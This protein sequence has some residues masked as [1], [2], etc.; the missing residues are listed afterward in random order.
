MKLDTRQLFGITV[1]SASFA[2]L[3][4]G[5]VSAQTPPPSA[6]QAAKPAPRMM[7]RPFSKPTDRVEAQLAYQKTALKITGAQELQWN[8][9]ANHVRKQAADM[10]QRFTKMR[11]ERGQRVQ[12]AQAG[13]QQQ[14]TPRQRPNAVERLERQQAMLAEASRRLNERL[15]VQKPLYAA[16]SPEQQ[17]LADVVLGARGGKEGRRG[18]KGGRGGHMH[19]GGFARG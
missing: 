1:L 13:T 8:A 17:K 7:E 3:G 2:A 4:V 6:T 15:A 9:Y 16:L 14:R 10:E 5:A 12:G 11:A 18:G 19:G